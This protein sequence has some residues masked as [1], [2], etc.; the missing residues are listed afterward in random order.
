M[1]QWALDC[2]FRN[3]LICQ[4]PYRLAL[5]PSWSCPATG[6][7]RILLWNPK[8]NYCVILS[9]KIPV[10]IFSPDFLIKFPF[11]IINKP[12][13]PSLHFFICLS[14]HCSFISLFLLFTSSFFS[15]CPGSSVHCLQSTR[16]HFLPDKSSLCDVTIHIQN[17]T[18]CTWSLVGL[19]GK[20]PPRVS[21]AKVLQEQTDMCCAVNTPIFKEYRIGGVCRVTQIL[22]FKV[23][24]LSHRSYQ[25]KQH[26][27]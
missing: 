2:L 16:L 26:D 20:S 5:Q 8:C 27:S 25:Q 11:H 17:L 3:V 23:L 19:K 9:Q 21:I 13:F 14:I 12:V 15:S 22:R 6:E 10:C 7:T 4:R 1:K 18:E 24:D